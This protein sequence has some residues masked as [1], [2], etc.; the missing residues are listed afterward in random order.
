ML[1][2]YV[3]DGFGFLA[4]KLVPGAGIQSMK[5]VRVTT[6]GASPALPLRMVAAGSGATVGVTLWVVAEGRW[7]PQ[8]FPSFAI[9][10]SDLEWTWSTSSSNFDALRAKRV[11]ELGGA[12]WEIESSID[13]S[14]TIVTSAIANVSSMPTT[15]RL[16]D[17]GF[18]IA[19]VYDDIP[20]ADG[21]VLTSAEAEQADMR[22]LF[23][24]RASSRVTRMRSDLPRASL[25]T[26]L[27]LQASSDQST[28][29]QFR[30]ITRETDEPQCGIYNGCT[31]AGT[32]PRSVAKVKAGASCGKLTS[33]RFCAPANQPTV[34]EDTSCDDDSSGNG[35]FGL[36]CSVPTGTST[37]GATST[38]LAA[39]LGMALMAW[40][41]NRARR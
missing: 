39:L 38:A 40:R 15:I 14:S 3:T 19:T 13:F 12:A 20:E 35:A 7:E 41:R 31:A 26:D 8:T 1:A 10:A 9:A 21:G 36:G 30:Q 29:S 22:A 37:D 4:L 18:G 28:L 27:T 5:P 32:A 17:G 2:S 23:Q 24:G 33:D 11:N 6:E 16:P 25:A 34:V